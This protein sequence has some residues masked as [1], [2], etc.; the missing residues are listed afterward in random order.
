MQIKK[1]VQKRQ[2]KK[3][4]VP[5]KQTA[6]Q[7]NDDLIV[8]YWYLTSPLFGKSTTIVKV[9]IVIV[10]WLVECW[11][12]CSKWGIIEHSILSNS[13]YLLYKEINN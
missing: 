4:N 7:N 6:D 11:V 3:I 1:K 2:F 10:K 9:I 12:F 13:K 5:Q 8:K